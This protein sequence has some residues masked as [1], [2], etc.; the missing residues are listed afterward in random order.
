MQASTG[1]HPFAGFSFL[2][3]DAIVMRARWNAELVWKGAWARAVH[4]LAERSVASAGT[5]ATSAPA[6]TPAGGG[7][8]RGH[9]RD[10]VMVA[11]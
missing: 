3:E 4:E 1:R 7:G 6:G 5:G 11:R 2:P 9:S 10:G 8:E